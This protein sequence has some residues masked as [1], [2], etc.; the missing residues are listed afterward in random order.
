MGIDYRLS[1]FYSQC[2]D[3]SYP[4]PPLFLICLTQSTGASKE[5]DT[6]GLTPEYL[7]GPVALR[8]SIAQYEKDKIMQGNGLGQRIESSGRVFHSRFSR[9]WITKLYYSPSEVIYPYS[10]AADGQPYR[11]VCWV[12]EDTYDPE[13]CKM[14][15][16]VEN[17]RSACLITY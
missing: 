15:L 2:L 12:L 8:E 3:G 1:T 5:G 14:L 16:E 4:C 13:A 10:W 9:A 17:K 11:D 7:T 6:E